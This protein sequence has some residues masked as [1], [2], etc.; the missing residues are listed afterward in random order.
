MPALL[1]QILSTLGFIA[2]TH[3]AFAAPQAISESDNA[4]SLFNTQS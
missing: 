4:R 2:F 1:R 3:T